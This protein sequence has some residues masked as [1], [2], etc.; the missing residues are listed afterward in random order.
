MLKEEYIYL[1]IYFILY[2]KGIIFELCFVCM[3]Y[4]QKKRIKKCT[5]LVKAKVID[6]VR[7]TSTDF[8]TLSPNVSWY[9]VY[10][11]QVGF[12]KKQN[13]SKIGA[14]SKKYEKGDVVSLYVDPNH[15]DDFYEP[16]NNMK[17]AY[18]IF[19]VIGICMIIACIILQICK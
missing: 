8:D 17:I 15:L 16:N 5:L 13:K 19:G 11:Y 2:F 12:E 1:F 4:T 6:I 10:E 7:V 14:A 18:S 9:P 3:F